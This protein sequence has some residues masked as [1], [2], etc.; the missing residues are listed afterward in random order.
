MTHQEDNYVRQLKV[1]KQFHWLPWG[2]MVIRN[3]GSNNKLSTFKTLKQFKKQS[4]PLW[5]VLTLALFRDAAAEIFPIY[6]C[7]HCQ[8]MKSVQSLSLSQSKLTIR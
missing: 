4:E 6:I 8:C 3:C 5:I 2:N 1:E 7:S